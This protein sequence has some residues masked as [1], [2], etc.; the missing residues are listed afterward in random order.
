[1]HQQL[2]GAYQPCQKSTSPI[3]VPLASLFRLVERIHSA[4][5]PRLAD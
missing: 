5:T 3:Q 2:I 4:G 1:M